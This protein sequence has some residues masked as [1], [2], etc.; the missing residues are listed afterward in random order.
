MPFVSST[1][2]NISHSSVQA[3]VSSVLYSELTLGFFRCVSQI[4]FFFSDTLTSLTGS[5]EDT[6]NNF[7]SWVYETLQKYSWSSHGVSS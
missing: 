1:V 5:W 7:S 3:A 2:F 6:A 4:F